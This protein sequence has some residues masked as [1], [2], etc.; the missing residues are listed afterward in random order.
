MLKT[1]VIAALILAALVTLH[2][3]KG[4]DSLHRH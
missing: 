3:V 1:V 2:I 4:G